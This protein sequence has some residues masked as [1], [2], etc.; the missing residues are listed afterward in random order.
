MLL[1]S[2]RAAVPNRMRVLFSTAIL[3]FGV[4]GS[5]WAA[6]RPIATLTPGS[7]PIMAP[8]KALSTNPHYFADGSGKAIY[9]TGSHTWNDFQDWGT[10]SSI[11]PLDFTAYVNMLVAH[12]HNFTLLWQTEL[13]TFR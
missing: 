8:L 7:K 3:L 11:Q 9:L 5:V 12:N 10:G 2:L 1:G 6:P 13:P 4:T